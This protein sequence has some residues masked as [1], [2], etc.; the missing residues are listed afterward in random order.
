MFRRVLQEKLLIDLIALIS[1]FAFF[2]NSTSSVLSEE[3]IFMYS[4]SVI[5]FFNVSTTESDDRSERGNRD[6]HMKNIIERFKS[7][8]PTVESAGMMIRCG[9]LSQVRH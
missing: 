2:D 1:S 6:W 7:A 3:V 9:K 4:S 8:S 5:Y